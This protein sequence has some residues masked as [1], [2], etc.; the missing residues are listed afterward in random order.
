MEI[1]T[2]SQGE[3][4]SGLLAALATGNTFGYLATALN[5]INEA[6]VQVDGLRNVTVNGKKMSDYDYY[7]S[8]LD[9]F[10]KIY[11]RISSYEILPL[12]GFS[13]EEVENLEKIKNLPIEERKTEIQKIF[14]RLNLDQSKVDFSN[15]QDVTFQFLL[16]LG[17]NLLSNKTALSKL[18]GEVYFVEIND[19]IK[20]IDNYV[21]ISTKTIEDED[22]NRLVIEALYMKTYELN[23]KILIDAYEKV[24]HARIDI[25]EKEAFTKVRE[26][27]KKTYPE[28]DKAM[29]N[30]PRVGFA[31]GKYKKLEKYNSQE[32]SD[33]SVRNF[34]TAVVGV[35]SKTDSIANT[36][37]QDI[38]KV[39]NFTNSSIDLSPFF[40]SED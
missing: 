32:L 24:H 25:S 6:K 21:K 12:L 31:H 7:P 38:Q 10:S 39:K 19:I 9:S 1:D 18:S 35:V 27:I 14:S 22:V 33:M 36:F 34:I 11:T 13:I 8:I 30:D 37:G 26:W 16:Q 2:N 40:K 17:N 5:K 29:E 23:K 20:G 3:K 28:L 4:I 15:P